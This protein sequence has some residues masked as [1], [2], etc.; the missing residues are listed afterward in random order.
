MRLIDQL[1][2]IDEVSCP[3]SDFFYGGVGIYVS[4]PQPNERAESVYQ[5]AFQRREFFPVK[6]I[7]LS[8]GY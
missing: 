7:P 6:F 4:M 5:V 2:I 1:P 3:L 8:K